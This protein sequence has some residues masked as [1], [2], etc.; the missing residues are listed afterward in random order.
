MDGEE[1]EA[2][3]DNL[4]KS[5]GKVSIGVL[6]KPSSFTFVPVVRK[7]PIESIITEKDRSGALTGKPKKNVAVLH[8]EIAE[9]TMSDRE[10][11]K[12]EKVIIK[13][14]VEGEAGNVIQPETQH[15]LKSSSDHVSLSQTQASPSVSAQSENMPNHVAA[16]KTSMETAVDKHRGISQRQCHGT[17][18]LDT[19]D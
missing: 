19:Q 2:E 9:E 5:L 7:L 6:S 18:G 14:S 10:I 3:M 1:F 11:F 13:D 8:E 4:N 17:S 12:A 15:Q 16:G